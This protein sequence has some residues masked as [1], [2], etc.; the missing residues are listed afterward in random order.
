MNYVFGFFLKTNNRLCIERDI[1]LSPFT[2]LPSSACNHA[3][4]D[5]TGD[6][7]SGDCVGERAYNLYETQGGTLCSDKIKDHILK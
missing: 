2:R 3:C 1:R 5:N 6:M 7:Y 4:E